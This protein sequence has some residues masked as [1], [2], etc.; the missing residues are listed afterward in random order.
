MYLL[1]AFLENRLQNS[2]AICILH[3]LFRFVHEPDENLSVNLRKQKAL[4]ERE[5]VNE[6]F[7]EVLVECATVFDSINK[8][9][10]FGDNLGGD[11]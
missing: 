3:H 9:V 6:K 2:S 8:K 10:T 4:S 5:K 7:A 11:I 1:V